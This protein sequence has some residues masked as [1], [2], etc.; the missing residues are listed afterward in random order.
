MRIKLVHAIHIH[1][2][3]LKD[4]PSDLQEELTNEKRVPFSEMS[5]A[6]YAVIARCWSDKLDGVWPPAADDVVVGVVGP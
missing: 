1:R 6:A 3:Y 2:A 5:S 4:G